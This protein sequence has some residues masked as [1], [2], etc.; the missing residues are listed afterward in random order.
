MNE[1]MKEK[2]INALLKFVKTPEGE[3]AL[4]DIYNVAG[5][6][7]ARDSDYDDLRRVLEKENIN[8]EDLM[9]N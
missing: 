6:I 9:K 4:F 8:F 1:I 7:P 3:K 2:I 5:L